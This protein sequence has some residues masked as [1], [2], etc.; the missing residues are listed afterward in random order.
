[1]RGPAMRRG[2]PAPWAGRERAPCHA[3]G[4]F[5]GIAP[6]A[7]YHLSLH[8]PVSRGKGQSLV[9]TAAYNE[10][11]EL[12]DQRTG[13]SH[14]YRDKG[15]LL[16]SGIFAPK[17]APEWAHDLGKLANE[18]ERVEKRKDAQL[19]MNMD[20][21]LPCEQTLEQNR[22]AVRDFV[23][24]NFSRQGYVAHVAIHEPDRD[25]D[26]RNTHAHILVSMRKL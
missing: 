15:G 4:G 26:Q 8:D 1:M 13:Q 14:D 2:D 9:R 25:G 11:T 21:A 10:R 7:T 17:D 6:V 3:A 12:T 16:W 24:E 22:R 18:I 23:R 19:A 20:L 5:L